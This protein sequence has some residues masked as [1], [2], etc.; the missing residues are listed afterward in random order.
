MHN[1]IE[2]LFYYLCVIN[3][4][5]ESRGFLSVIFREVMESSRAYLP[6]MKF[7]TANRRG[8]NVFSKDDSSFI[9]V[10]IRRN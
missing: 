2:Y 4:R 7:L 1:Y 6:R 8:E 5:T 3:G 9:V 10:F